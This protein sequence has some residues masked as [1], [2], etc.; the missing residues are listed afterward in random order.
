MAKTFL[1]PKPM[2][3]TSRPEPSRS[4]QLDGNLSRTSTHKMWMGQRP[5]R[6]GGWG[7]KNCKT[8]ESCLVLVATE[9]FVQTNLLEIDQ[10]FW[11][12]LGRGLEQ[13]SLPLIPRP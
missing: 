8:A 7:D 12:T 10:R 11:V 13:P 2:L 4:C 1:M 5:G 9:T 3:L 6:G